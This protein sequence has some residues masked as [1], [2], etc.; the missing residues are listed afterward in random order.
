MSRV[1]G[2]GW[3]LQGV[4]HA[5][6]GLSK[7]RAPSFAGKS[8]GG[9]KASGNVRERLLKDELAVDFTKKPRARRLAP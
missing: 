6:K 5:A 7:W 9:A 3:G 8:R 2:L 4:T 1:R